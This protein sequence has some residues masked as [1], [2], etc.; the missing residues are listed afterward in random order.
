HDYYNKKPSEF[1]KNMFKRKETYSRQNDYVSLKKKLEEINIK[2]LLNENISL[3]EEVE[4]FPEI[5]I[6]GVDDPIINKMDL[7]K[8]LK[9][10]NDNPGIL[11]HDGFLKS[12]EYR[13]AFTVSGLDK[14]NIKN[15]NSLR[16]ALIHTP[17]SYALANLSLNG[18]DII[19]AGHTHGGQVR[20][21][22]KGAII[23]GCSIKT[24]FA[25]GLF[26]FNDFVLQISK[27]LGEGRFSKFR[28]YCQPEAI[29]TKLFI[30]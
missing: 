17:D 19:F 28:I 1:L 29:I 27:G 20:M 11:E 2:V 30:E 12:E 5:E 10:I 14:H 8:S 13:Q 4:G 25:S 21:P 22:G 6:I 18:A 3:D 23:S 16:I 7:R 15:K 26:Y 24:R 9:G